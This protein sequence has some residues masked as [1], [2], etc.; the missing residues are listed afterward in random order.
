MVAPEGPYH[1]CS[2]A[3]GVGG[4]EVRTL[5]RGGRMHG[6]LYDEPFELTAPPA[7]RAVVPAGSA[8]FA[9]IF[10]MSGAGHFSA[11]AIREAA[12]HGVPA[13]GLLVPISGV[14]ALLGGLSVL[15]G[16]KARLGALALAGF[17]AVVTPAMHA[18]WNV[19][20]PT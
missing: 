9:A 2:A 17:L 4:V 19:A 3:V 1:R 5:C 14:V 18:F 7:L 13:P 6:E 11:A 15:L 16:F 10:L 20:D 12:A 8:L